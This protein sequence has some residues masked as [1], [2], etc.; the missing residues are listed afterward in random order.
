MPSSDLKNSALAYPGEPCDPQS[1]W[2]E[3]EGRRKRT[4]QAAVWEEPMQTL[5]GS[6]T[7]S[8]AMTQ[9]VTWP[10]DPAKD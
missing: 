4:Y 6:E 2:I 10:L 3:Q 5:L 8:E 9:E 1:Y 7:V